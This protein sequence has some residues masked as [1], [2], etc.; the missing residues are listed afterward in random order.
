MIDWTLAWRA[1]A[2]MR[3]D[4]NKN[5]IKKQVHDDQPCPPAVRAD[6]AAKDGPLVDEGIADLAKGHLAEAGL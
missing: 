2:T 6:Y 5:N 1:N 4:Y 3:L